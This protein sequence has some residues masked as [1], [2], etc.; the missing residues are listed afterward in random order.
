METIYFILGIV[1]LSVIFY[2]ILKEYSYA[3]FQ[4]TMKE[5]DECRIFDEYDN[6]IYGTITFVFDNTVY[7]STL[8]GKYT[9][10]QA[11]VYPAKT[12]II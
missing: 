2:Y 3:Q 7:I 8:Y 9:R 12:I 1:A 11:E 5:G 6:L 4:K 10:K